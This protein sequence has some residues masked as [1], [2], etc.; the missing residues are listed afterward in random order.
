MAC[1]EMSD[2]QSRKMLDEPVQSGV[3]EV[4]GDRVGEYT[5]AAAAAGLNF[6]FR[7]AI[8]M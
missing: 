4:V 2:R 5:A 3:L 8:M 7:G 6:V 1:C